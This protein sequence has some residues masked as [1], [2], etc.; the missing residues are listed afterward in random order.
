[1][2]Q[3]KYEMGKRAVEILLQGKI[4]NSDVTSRK[5]QMQSSMILR[6]TCKKIE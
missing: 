4:K 1:M 5:V 2:N 3:P 6:K